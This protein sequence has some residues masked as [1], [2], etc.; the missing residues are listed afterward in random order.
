MLTIAA[1]VRIGLFLSSYAILF[2]ILAL[3]FD[4]FELRLG[5][6]ALAVL[7]V[8]AGIWILSAEN[9]K[10]PAAYA[11][12]SADDQGPDAA[13]YMASYLLP[14]VSLAE[15]P[16]P[17]VIGY[18]AFG[19]VAAVVYTQSEM[20][21]VNPLLYLVGRRIYKIKTGA[22]W[23]GYV[24]ARRPPVSGEQ[25][26]ATTFASDILVEARTKAAR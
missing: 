5:C 24:V 7:G 9:T 1:M 18:L 10:G 2:A 17:D 8:G 12:V 13:S 4:R 19:L 14:F 21:R 23:Q 16:L 3:R 22:G 6:V 15:P 25:I 26:L 11:V 20:V